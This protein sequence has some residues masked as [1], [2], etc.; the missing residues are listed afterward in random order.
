MY[1]YCGNNPINRIDISGTSWRDVVNLFGDVGN[2]IGNFFTNTFGGAVYISNSYDAIEMN[3]IY[4][5]YET[6]MSTSRVIAG[7]N[8]KP[9]TFYAQ[10]SSKWWKFWEYKVGVNV[11]IGEG[12]FNI[13]I[14]YGILAFL[15]P[16][17][18]WIMYF[19]WKDSTPHRASQAN[20]LAWIGFTLNLIC[21][22][23]S[24]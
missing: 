10:K 3:T 18:G 13:G 6:G 1:I 17:A 20:T 15:I 22:W 11:N 14:G 23:A 2:T 16:I 9:I 5:G 24:M 7:D 12:G 19:V 8:S 4:V 21:F